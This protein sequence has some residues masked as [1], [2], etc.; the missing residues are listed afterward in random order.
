MASLQAKH[1]R[2][3]EIGKAWT[4]FA[5]AVDGC[6]CALGPVYYVVIREGGR[7]DKIRVGRN[8]KEA[9]RALRKLAVEVDE[10]TY[11]PQPNIA[12]EDWADRW[13]TSL[14]G[15]RTTVR[16]YLST[17]TYAKRAFGRMSVRKLRPEHVSRLNEELRAAGLSASTRAKH[18]RV[19]GA[20]LASA[21]RHGY[22]GRN[23]VR[24]LAPGEKPRPTQKESA[25]SENHELPRLFS[26]LSPGLY[27]TLF[28]LALKTG[29]RQGEVLAL[30]WGDIDLN[31][32]VIH[33]RRSVA[34]GEAS[35]PKNH[36]R[37]V[38]DL[39][40]DVV[41]LLGRWWG[42]SGSAI[43]GDTLAFPGESA[44]GFIAGSTLL[45]RGALPRHAT[46][47]H[48]THRTDRRSTHF[49]LTSPHVR[50]VRTRIG[51]AAHVA[52][53]TAGSFEHA[54]DRL[55]VRSLRSGLNGG[56]KRPA[57]LACSGSRPY[58]RRLL[59]HA[60]HVPQTCCLAVQRDGRVCRAAADRGS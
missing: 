4:P 25:Y 49:S 40:P 1:S 11:R 2:Q 28:L 39:T 54:S 45:R 60:N 42:D 58:V 24:D 29:M 34:D 38:V 44:G 53:S 19:L 51:R 36:E 17:M 43:D 47:G 41:D 50:E 8:R 12:F 48:P 52:V 32:A 16:S 30:R 46:S 37:R 27:K 13:L 57:L 35:S 6:S 7:A 15:K 18:L 23:P 22:A 14:E 33:V 56:H 31:E 21:V 26:E 3:C 5:R 55:D 10:G 9:E 59:S 20:C